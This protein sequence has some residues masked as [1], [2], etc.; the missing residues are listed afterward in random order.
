MRNLKV[1]ALLSLGLMI[2]PY[3]HAQRFGVEIGVAPAPVY[4][5]P[6]PVCPY[7]YYDFYPYSCVP[8][9][10]YGPSYFSSGVFIGVGPWGHGYHGRP[11][12]YAGRGYYN[13]RGYDRGPVVRERAYAGRG[14][15]VSGHQEFRA[16]RS[17]AGGGGNVRGGRGQSF[18]GGGGGARGASRGDGDRKSVV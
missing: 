2:A 1:L 13:G 6:P 7:G 15:A 16:G 9:G 17:Y 18:T 5:G 8:Y 4:V 14:P 12:Y 11:G 3:A 10:Y